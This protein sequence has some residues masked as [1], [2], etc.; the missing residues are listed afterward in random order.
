MF[1]ETKMQQC[2]TLTSV[3]LKKGLQATYEDVCRKRLHHHENNSIWHTRNNWHTELQQL[4]H[5]IQN[6][7]FQ[8]SQ[9]T[10][11]KTS[12]SGFVESF[13]ATDA[14]VLT[15]LASFIAKRQENTFQI[16]FFI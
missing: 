1:Y 12:E 5:C 13:E 3:D 14:I 6:K 7:S 4:V 8:F 2:L 16:M 10:L 9:S 15:Y 11:H